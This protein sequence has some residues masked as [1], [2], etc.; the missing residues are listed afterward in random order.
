MGS[1]GGEAEGVLVMELRNMMLKGLSPRN[2]MVSHY[3]VSNKWMDGLTDGREGWDTL[4][5]LHCRSATGPIAE[6]A[7][8]CCALCSTG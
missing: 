5:C 4:V 3:E 7:C 1:K 2:T 6:D 8:I